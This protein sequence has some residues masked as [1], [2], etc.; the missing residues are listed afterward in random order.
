MVRQLC[1]L[2]MLIVLP[3]M[4][5]AHPVHRRVVHHH[6]PVTDATFKGVK[7]LVY[8]TATSRHAP[9]AVQP[10]HHYIAHYHHTATKGPPILEAQTTENCLAMA[11]YREAKSESAQGQAAVGYV[12]MN[13]VTNRHF[14]NSACGVVYQRARDSTGV[15]HCQ[16]SWA[17]ESPHG[18][19]NSY[20]MAQAHRIAQGVLDR[21]VPNPIGDALYF[22]ES[23][24][25]LR[26]SRHAPYHMVLG[27]HVFY[28]PTPLTHETILASAGPIDRT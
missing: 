14:P 9:Q 23:C 8:T 4:T 25:A 1:F 16:F 5:V 11:I 20:Q 2:L 24:V 6:Q 10:P 22:H 3:V 13:R 12:V 26:P 17:C 21:S 19:I 27:H 15:V 18:K 7:G 28:S